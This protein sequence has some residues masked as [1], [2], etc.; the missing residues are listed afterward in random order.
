MKLPIAATLA[1]LLFASSIGGLNASAAGSRGISLKSGSPHTITAA[2]PG[3]KCKA[4]STI[5]F[6]F[7][8]TGIK[9]SGAM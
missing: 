5:T 7:R 8:V 4:P 2:A 6:S 3:K 9:F 1:G